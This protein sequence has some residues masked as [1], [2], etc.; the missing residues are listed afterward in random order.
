MQEFLAV[1]LADTAERLVTQLTDAL[2][3]NIHGLAH[4]AKRLGS[5]L[6]DTE[7][8]GNDLRFALRELFHQVAG[9]A[10]YTLD[11]GIG[12]RVGGSVVGKHLG[13]CGLGVRLQG[14]IERHAALTDLDKLANLFV[15]L[16][17]AALFVQG[18][19]HTQVLV[20]RQADQVTLLVDGAGNVGL[21]PPHAITDELEAAGVFKG[22]DGAHQAHCPLAHQVRQRNR[23]ATVLDSHFQN[24]THIGRNQSLSSNLVAFLRLLEKN[25]FFFAGEGGC[26][27]NVFEVSF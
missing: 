14:A 18:L 2:V 27:S 15:N 1:V 11:F 9:K 12:L 10:F 3:R 23:A 13:V 24:E 8:A 6:V 4:F 22:L 25:L 20:C 26:A 19:A 21:D 5:F 16:F 7:N 17:T